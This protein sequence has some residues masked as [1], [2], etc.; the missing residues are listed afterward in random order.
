MM[1]MVLLMMMMARKLWTHS[2]EMKKIDGSD[3][4]LS[5]IY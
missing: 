4:T 2:E 3:N 1:V 5:G